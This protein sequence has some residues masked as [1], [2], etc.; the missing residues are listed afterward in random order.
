MGLHEVSL[1][2]FCCHS[3]TADRRRQEPWSC[4]DCWE[5]ALLV[6][7]RMRRRFRNSEAS[8]RGFAAMTPFIVD[9]PLRDEVSSAIQVLPTSQQ[10]VP[11]PNDP[12]GQWH[13]D[14]ITHRRV[15]P[16]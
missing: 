16:G 7:I 5:P 3:P 10:Q 2:P 6:T 11:L 4:S 14:R 8:A 12:L 13:P 1:L 9:Q 15:R